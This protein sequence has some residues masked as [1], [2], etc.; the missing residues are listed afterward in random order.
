MTLANAHF[1]VS[2]PKNEKVLSYAPGTKER[3]DLKA[4][5]CGLKQQKIEIPLII[6]GR[7]VRTGDMGS[8]VM[9]HNKGHLIGTYHK[10]GEKE[11][12]EAV[13]AALSAR[14]QWESMPWEHR[15]A[16]FLRA[17]ELIAGPYRSTINAATM[18]CQSKTA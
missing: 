6:G 10:A 9:P 8:C 11:A 18:L 13:D 7:E 5:L 17:A 15:A 2:K 12:K 14:S 4:C 16:I 3:A 1:R